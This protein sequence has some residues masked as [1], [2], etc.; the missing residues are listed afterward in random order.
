MTDA[1]K[2]FLLIYLYKRG[3]RAAKTAENNLFLLNVS[4]S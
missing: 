2:V 4:E 1:V 3:P